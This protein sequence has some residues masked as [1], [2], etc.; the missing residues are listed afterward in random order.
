[1][2]PNSLK[3][4]KTVGLVGGV[5]G[6]ADH[7]SP[8]SKDLLLSNMQRLRALS[9]T[10]QEHLS[11]CEKPHSEQD[12][13]RNSP[14][15]RSMSPVGYMQYALSIAKKASPKP[16]N[17]SV[18][19]VI[20]DETENHILAT[21][22][23]NE[24]SGNMHAEQCALTKLETKLRASPPMWL[25][26]D[27]VLVL[28]TTMEPCN[29]RSSG[30]IPCTETILDFNQ[31]PLTKGIAKVY[32]GVKEPEKFVEANR[33]IEKLETQGIELQHVPGLEKD[34]VEVATAGHQPANT[35]I[36]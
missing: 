30:N 20:V 6:A 3:L 25:S 28:Y 15:P 14:F 33:G 11:H 32:F 24:L 23:T 7:K 5:P 21:G 10:V 26:P 12:L 17:F 29:K 36:Q 4:G 22:Y 2:R 9:N 1:M 27:A 16:T 19:A 31:K 8:P 18:G 35:A 34:I 13:T